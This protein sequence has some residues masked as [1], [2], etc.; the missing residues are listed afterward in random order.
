[1][2]IG[3]IGIRRRAGTDDEALQARCAKPRQVEHGLLLGRQRELVVIALRKLGTGDVGK[4]LFAILPVGRIRNL[5]SV[6][7]QCAAPHTGALSMR[8][9][10]NLLRR[11]LAFLKQSGQ[12][13]IGLAGAQKATSKE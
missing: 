9:I 2:A 10:V 6:E 4:L 13:R 7:P 12:R 1:M 8:V 3:G 11:W 5:T